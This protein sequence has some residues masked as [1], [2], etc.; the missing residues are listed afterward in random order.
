[1]ATSHLTTVQKAQENT[2]IIEEERYGLG[3]KP[4]IILSMWLR[5]EPFCYT[6]SLCGRPFILPEDRNP[7]EGMEEVW[8]AFNQ[9]VGEEHSTVEK[10]VG[11]LVV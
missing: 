2:G 4:R 7:K 10:E 6:C 9:H 5:G 11:T 1:M 8:A 3:G